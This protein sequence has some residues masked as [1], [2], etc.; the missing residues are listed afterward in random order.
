MSQCDVIAPE[1]IVAELSDADQYFMRIFGK[2]RLAIYW[3]SR[4]CQHS[5]KRYSTFNCRAI[6]NSV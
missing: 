3:Y 4:R 2:F 5:A 6:N 1:N